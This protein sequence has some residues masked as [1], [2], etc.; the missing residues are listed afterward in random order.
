[1]TAL[2]GERVHVLSLNPS[3][4]VT[5]DPEELLGGRYGRL[6]SAALDLEGGLWLTTSNKDGVGTPGE[7]DDKVLRILPPSAQADSPL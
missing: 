5:G 2:D 4:A 7:G 1:V 6:R 3:G